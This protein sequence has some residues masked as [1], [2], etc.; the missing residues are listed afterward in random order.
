[1]SVLIEG[2]FEQMVA[3][4][5]I[6]LQ[7]ELNLALPATLLHSLVV[8]NPSVAQPVLFS[9]T[10]EDSRTS[11]LSQTGTLRSQRVHE[12]IIDPTGCRWVHQLPNQIVEVLVK[13]DNGLRP[14]RLGGIKVGMGQNSAQYFNVSGQGLRPKTK[15]ENV[16][17]DIGTGTVSSYGKSVEVSVVNEPWLGV[18]CG[19]FG[20]VGM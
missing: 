9:N 6:F 7:K 5:F 19:V 8:P 13:F 20:R 11:K 12:G 18:V 15:G 3:M 1:M 4:V 16:V 2:R 14:N 10:D 17:D